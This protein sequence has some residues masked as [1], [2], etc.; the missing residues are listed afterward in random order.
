MRPKFH[1][2]PPKN[3]MN[4]PNGLI[5]FKGYYHIFYQHFP[6]E[7]HWGTMHW[8]HAITK[9]FIHYKH[10]PIALYPSKPYDQNGCFSGSA[11]SMHNQLYL[12]YT[13]IQYK[14]INENNIHL[15]NQEDDTIASQ[16]MLVSEDGFHFDNKTKHLITTKDPQS[17]DPKAWIGKNGHVYLAI[18]SHQDGVGCVLFYESLDGK[19]F[20]KINTYANPLIGDMWECPDIFKLDE[21]YFLMICP[22][23]ITQPPL[24]NCNS[25]IMPIDFHEDTCTISNVQP[26][27]FLDYGLDFYAPQTFID[28]NKNTCILG[29]LRMRKPVENE[30][31]VGML[32]MPRILTHKDGHIYQQPYPTII[33]QF[34]KRCPNVSLAAPFKLSIQLQDDQSI[35]L[36]NFIITFKNN[37]LICDRT[38]VSISHPKVSNINKSPNIN[39]CDLTIYYDF[40]VFEIYINDGK[41]VMTQV[42]YN[43]DQSIIQLPH[44][45]Y[46]IF[47]F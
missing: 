20:T 47:V 38:K 1:F 16:A 26:Y 43:L 44:Q 45:H 6:Y 42:V 14:S 28:E 46:D 10:L 29:W 34:K 22:E 23:N 41:Y 31:Y 32:S 25:I 15:R 4:D 30:N 7:C 39:T 37:T 5:Y 3:W 11:I 36:G 2:T 9:D 35:N 21:Q 17:R 13:A 18:G 19:Q 24:P 27:Q 8:G 33:N 40:N 12:Y